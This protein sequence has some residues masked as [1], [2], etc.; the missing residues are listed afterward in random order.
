MPKQQQKKSGGSRK[1]GRN[2]DKCASYKIFN[3]REKN[4]VRRVLKSSGLQEATRWA[5]ENGV[6]AYLRTLV[7]D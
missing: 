6:S 7:R 1:I 4:K 2:K 5:A 3:T